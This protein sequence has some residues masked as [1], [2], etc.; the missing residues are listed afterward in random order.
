MPE[1]TAQ[2]QDHKVYIIGRNNFN[3][4]VNGGTVQGY[5]FD[6]MSIYFVRENTDTGA[7]ELVSLYIGGSKQSDVL[8][9]TGLTAQQY[10]GSLSDYNI[11]LDYAIKNKVIVRKHYTQQEEEQLGFNYYDMFV[12]DGVH[13]RMVGKDTSDFVT[14]A[15][16]TAELQGY[17]KTSDLNDYAT[18]AYVQ[19]ALTNVV[20]HDADG[21]VTLTGTADA[22]HGNITSSTGATLTTVRESISNVQSNTYTFN[23]LPTNSHEV[24]ID[25]TTTILSLTVSDIAHMGNS[26]TATTSDYTCVLI[27]RKNS[28]VADATSLMTNFNPTGNTPKIYLLNPDYDI[29]D[30]TVIHIFIFYDGM[31]MCAIVAGYDDTPPL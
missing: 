20:F 10:S 4:L 12:Y 2:P 11:P 17:V 15:E 26:S 3:T 5:T 23:Y 31:N 8:D 1:I 16:L 27:F 21:N 19:A 28:S 13:F 18:Q 29:S 22:S 14:Q 30:K 7:K 25:I 9:I 24:L 6:D